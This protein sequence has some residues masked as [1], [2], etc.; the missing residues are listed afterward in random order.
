[1]Y[2]APEFIVCELPS[3]V[4][5][6]LQSI[7]TDCIFAFASAFALDDMYI[8]FSASKHLYST[9]PLF[10][11][12]GNI[13]A[14]VT[15][16]V[17]HTSSHTLLEHPSYFADPVP[18]W[19]FVTSLADVPHTGVDEPAA[20]VATHGYFPL[21]AASTPPTRRKTTAAEATIRWVIFLTIF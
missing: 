13:V 21:A 19:L 8:K 17:S 2:I 16:V 18:H 3:V 1:M 7:A 20:H 12:T 9:P 14:V 6:V 5:A 4:P 15:L 10:T 11:V